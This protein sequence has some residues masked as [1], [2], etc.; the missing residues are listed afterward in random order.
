MEPMGCKIIKLWGVG[1]E[2]T[3]SSML[4]KFFEMI[5]DDIGELVC[6]NGSAASISVV[7][8]Y[9]ST[10]NRVESHT[11]GTEVSSALITM[12][13]TAKDMTEVRRPSWYVL[14]AVKTSL[15]SL[16]SLSK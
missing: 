2:R 16:C 10:G 13:V 9:I 6:S 5:S 4:G 14:H 15:K 1:T 3:C 12:F 8:L 11:Y 7:I